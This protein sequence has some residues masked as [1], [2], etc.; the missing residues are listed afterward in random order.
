[1]LKIIDNEAIFGF[2]GPMLA[3][4]ERQEDLR[5]KVQD[6]CIKPRHYK[7]NPVSNRGT[8]HWLLDQLLKMGYQCRVI[9]EDR[10]IVAS[11]RHLTQNTCYTLVG[12]HYDTVPDSPGADD[13]GSAVI[14]LLELARRNQRENV[15]F[16]L[17]NQEEDGLLG[18]KAVAEQLLDK[19]RLDIAEV[20]ILEMIGF[21]SEKQGTPPG[22]PELP[23][24]K[25]DFI[26]FISDSKSKRQCDDL[27]QQA[28]GY[29]LP[30]VALQLL[31]P[32]R[33][34]PPVLHRS[35]HSPF[36][37]FGIPAILWTDTAEFRSPHY[38]QT[39]DTAD[40]LD[41]VFMDKVI[42]VLNQYLQ[43]A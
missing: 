32:T 10:N 38:H 3:P 17:F 33:N 2:G 39:T 37:E 31:V 16:A 35:D 20:H 4:E 43:H 30:A 9:G 42:G 29:G 27:L 28:A 18:S 12:A 36:W 23:R 34:A 6:F 14:G 19:D 7:Q 25:G 41:Y 15:I 40:T 8:A 11:R 13:N 24:S 5:L 1:M 26:A 21:T 22:F